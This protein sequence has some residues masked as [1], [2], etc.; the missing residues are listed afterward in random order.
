MRSVPNRRLLFLGALLV[1]A[2]LAWAGSVGSAELTVRESVE[3]QQGRELARLWCKHCHLVEPEGSGYVQSNV[4]TFAE[5]A[6]R[7]DQSAEQIKL[8][9]VDPH[10][11][12]PN[13]NLS[14]D[15]IQNLATY[16]LS[17]KSEDGN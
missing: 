1:S 14:R 7:P 5:I 8:F 4:P 16:I 13:L 10:P 17:L 11:P 9:L 15:E 12:M 6:N 2:G 3:A